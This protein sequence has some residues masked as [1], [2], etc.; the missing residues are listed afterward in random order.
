M[1]LDMGFNHL[2]CFVTKVLIR[3]LSL[4]SFF[5]STTLLRDVQPLPVK[6]NTSVPKASEMTLLRQ[7]LAHDIL[8]K[9]GMTFSVSTK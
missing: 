9:S 5:W 8:K 6:G 1:L 2:A 7:L 4:Q 3:K